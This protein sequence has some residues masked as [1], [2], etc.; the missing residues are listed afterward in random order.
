MSKIVIDDKLL[1]TFNFHRRV[2]TF[3]VFWNDVSTLYN[4]DKN[5]EFYCAQVSCIDS[6]KLC[7]I[8]DIKKPL[9]IR[10]Y[11]FDKKFQPEKLQLFVQGVIDRHVKAFESELQMIRK[12]SNGKYLIFFN[13]PGCSHCEEFHPK[14]EQLMKIHE[15]ATRYHL[16]NVSCEAYEEVCKHFN[17]DEYPTF[18]FAENYT[19]I[20]KY[21]GEDDV[22][23]IS[24]F[25][26]KIARPN[27]IKIKK[28]PS[29]LL[30]LDGDSFFDVVE[31][32]LTFIQYELPGCHYCDV[33][34]RD[35]SIIFF[36]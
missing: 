28:Y 10:Y 9:E 30:Q 25:L 21:E 5:A 8:E 35:L 26:R 1:I 2:P 36:I 18:S 4:D 34:L 12:L 7:K 20:T 6:P 11:P 19:K 24:L 15:N 29:G 17:I 16:V 33:S 3:D 27:V 23:P 13:T 14:W 22:I 31:K 32:N